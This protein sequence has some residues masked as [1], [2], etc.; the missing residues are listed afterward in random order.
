[1]RQFNERIGQFIAMVEH[2]RMLE[3]DARVA[4]S[5]AW[6]LNPT[7]NPKAGAK[8][9]INQEELGLLAGLSRQATNR[10]LKAL[11]ASGLIRDESD[12]LRALDI[13]KLRNYG[14]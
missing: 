6:L 12:G 5:I 13:K 8:I 3:A 9:D 1:M 4:R 10:A 7:L 11:E 14:G 2:D